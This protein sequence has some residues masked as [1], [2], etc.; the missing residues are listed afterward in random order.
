MLAYSM[1]PM[2]QAEM[3]SEPFG[4][5]DDAM[6]IAPV[7]NDPSLSFLISSSSRSAAKAAPQVP[8]P[9]LYLRGSKSTEELGGAKCNSE[10][11]ESAYRISDPM[12]VTDNTMQDVLAPI[13]PYV[14][15]TNTMSDFPTLS[16]KENIRPRRGSHD[17]GRLKSHSRSAVF[18]RR[19][20][21]SMQAAEEDAETGMVPPPPG[22][23]GCRS[24][25]NF[26]V[27]L[28]LYLEELR[29]QRAASSAIMI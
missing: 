16:A 10:C 19:R 17:G 27:G 22:S 9:K 15:S 7:C 1:V 4:L 3:F 18:G 25:Y 26:F 14:D 11:R 8:A 2:N 20:H 29:R 5:A 23:R 24:R 12:Q 28:T 13:G 21:S 6:N